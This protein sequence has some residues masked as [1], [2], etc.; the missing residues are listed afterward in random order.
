MF[1]GWR[2]LILSKISHP[3]R[4]LNILIICTEHEHNSGLVY[5]RDGTYALEDHCKQTKNVVSIVG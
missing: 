1:E 4:M 3:G 5:H 2:R